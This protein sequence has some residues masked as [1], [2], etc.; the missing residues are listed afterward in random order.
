ADLGADVIRVENAR[1][2][3]PAGARAAGS[4]PAS[5]PAPTVSAAT[6]ATA[7][8]HQVWVACQRGKRSVSI[9]MKAPKRLEI[10]QE[11]IAT[12]DV[13]HHNMRPGVADRL[14]IGYEDAK[15]LNPQIIYCHVTGFGTSGPLADFPG[16]D[17]M[18]QALSGLEYEQ[19]ATP[20]GGSPTWHRLGLTDHATALFS[21]LGVAQPLHR[22]EPY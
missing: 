17:Q 19:G 21:V 2:R 5:T 7:S 15:R 14:G 9:D 6:A 20:A 18:A 3:R 1:G 4:A 13:V 22:R 8:A 16:S 10:A 12:A 11:L